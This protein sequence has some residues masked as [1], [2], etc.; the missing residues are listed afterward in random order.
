MSF[1]DVFTGKKPQAYEQKGD[2]YAKE[3]LWGNAK[4]EYE[5]AMSRMESQASMDRES[6]DRLAKKV[7]GVRE[8]LAREHQSNAKNLVAG[9]F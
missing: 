8:E 7:A 3:G 1:F 2:T 5:R 6:A 9:G 4:V